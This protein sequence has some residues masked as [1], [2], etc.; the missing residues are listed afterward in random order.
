[1]YSHREDKFTNDYKQSLLMCIWEMRERE[2]DKGGV[3]VRVEL[4]VNTKNTVQ[5]LIDDSR[6]FS[7]HRPQ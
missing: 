6:I 4:I 3:V 5:D 1:M 7:K 2:M